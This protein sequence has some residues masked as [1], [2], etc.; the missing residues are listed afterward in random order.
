MINHIIDQYNIIYIKK[1]S[2]HYI[3]YE[4]LFN[5]LNLFKKNW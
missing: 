3:C 1:N 5:V 2:E 4:K